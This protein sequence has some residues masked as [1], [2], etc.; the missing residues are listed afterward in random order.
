MSRAALFLARFCSSGWMGAASLFVI[1]GILEVTQSSFDSTTKDILVTIR[2][3]SFYRLGPTLLFLAWLGACASKSHPELPDRRRAIAIFSLLTAI[4][5]MIVD[6]NWVYSPL[7]AMVTP[8]GQSKPAI[9]VTYHQASKY[10]NLTGLV[11]TLI[12][13]VVLNWP[14]GEKE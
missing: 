5:L 13:A 11:F 4:I 2:F 10:I 1:V 14:R 7:L 6:Y 12:A 9:F 8:A 3:P